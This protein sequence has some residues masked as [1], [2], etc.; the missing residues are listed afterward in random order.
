[1]LFLKQ[2]YYKMIMPFYSEIENKNLKNKI[3]KSNKKVIL[4]VKTYFLWR[5]LLLVKNLLNMFVLC[6]NIDFNS[7]STRIIVGL[8]R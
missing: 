8:F 1:M 4:T 7:L 2:L 6:I 5:G 3:N